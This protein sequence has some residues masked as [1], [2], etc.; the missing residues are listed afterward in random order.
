MY[1][2]GVYGDAE[3]G[4][5][6]HIYR[7]RGQTWAGAGQQKPKRQQRILEEAEVVVVDRGK[8]I[9]GEGRRE[10]DEKE[11]EQRTDTRL[12]ADTLTTAELVPP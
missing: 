2:E 3:L 7:H 6:A 4:A 5:R 9:S 8:E 10:E 1:G 11:R 12:A